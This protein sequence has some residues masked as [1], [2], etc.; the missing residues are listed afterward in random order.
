[1]LVIDSSITVA[2]LVPDERSAETQ[3]TLDRVIENGAVVPIHWRLEVGNALL[4]ALRRRRLSV[5]QRNEA[6][7]L[8]LSLQLTTDDDTIER[9]WIVTLDIAERFQL[10][11]YDACYLELAKRRRLPL[12]TLDRELRDAAQQIGVELAGP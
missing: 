2:W 5:H 12:A 3:R 6:L 10:T 11:L 1:L 7:D 4:M 9:A 8:L